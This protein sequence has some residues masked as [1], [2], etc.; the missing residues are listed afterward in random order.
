MKNDIQSNINSMGESKLSSFL[1]EKI[2]NIRNKIR[3]KKK[4][5]PNKDIENFEDKIDETVIEET[6]IKNVDTYKDET[7][8]VNAD[9]NNSVD[10]ADDTS[11]TTNNITSNNEQPELHSEQPII[12]Q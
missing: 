10:S 4:S 9:T 6:N 2:T 1:K 11:K 7:E 3:N 8:N 5:Q 12:A